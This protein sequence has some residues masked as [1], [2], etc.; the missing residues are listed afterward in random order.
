MKPLDK[1]LSLLNKDK[2]IPVIGAGVSFATAGLPGWRGAIENGLQYAEHRR[3]GEK[4]LMAQIKT[5]VQTGDLVKAANLLKQVLK[6]PNHPFV[7]WVEDLFGNPQIRSKALIDSIHDLCTPILLTTNYDDLLYGPYKIQEKKIFDWSLHG[8]IARSL[9]KN[10]EFILHLHGVYSKPDTVILSLADYDQLAGQHGYKS[11]LQKLWTDYHFLFIGCSRDGIMD[12]DFSTVIDFMNQWF[13]DFPHEHFILM[14]EPEFSTG[15]HHEL[16][17]KCNVHA[18]SYGR[19]YDDLPRFINEINPNREKTRLRRE[20]YLNEINNGLERLNASGALINNQAAV[21]RFVQNSLPVKAYWIDSE[22]LKILEDI[23][24]KYNAALHDKRQQLAASQAIVR[25]LISINKLDENIELWNQN[26]ANPEKLRKSGMIDTALMAFNCLRAFPKEMLDEIRLRAWGAIHGQYFDGNFDHFISEIKL[27]RTETNEHL[28][29]I[30]ADRYFFENM[31]RIIQS[32]QGV[33][34]LEPAKVFPE[35]NEAVVTKETN[36]GLLFLAQNNISLRHDEFPYPVQASL[37]GETSLSF[38]S[39]AFTGFESEKFVIGHTSQYVFC[40]NPN[41]DILLRKFYI[42]EVGSEISHV[43]NSRTGTDLYTYIFCSDKLVA[44]KNLERYFETPIQ[45]N[46]HNVVLLDNERGFLSST[47][48]AA[49]I[50]GN[51]ISRITING[52][53]SPL[54]TIQELWGIVYDIPAVYDVLHKITNGKVPAL[55]DGYIQGTRISESSWFGE[56][57]IIL[58]ATISLQFVKSSFLIVFQFKDEKLK[59]LSR[60]FFPHRFCY[61]HTLIQR[62]NEM[63]LVAGY[64]ATGNFPLI[65]YFKGINQVFDTTINGQPAIIQPL[66]KGNA[67]ILSMQAI[68]ADRVIAIQENERLYDIKL[69]DMTERSM[70]VKNLIRVTAVTS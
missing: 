10:E 26:W 50:T 37:P 17:E 25:G 9:Q 45:A 28:E 40:W 21:D 36:F 5:L 13:P 16:L 11:I 48:V 38:K 4:D 31:K 15:V 69:Q 51:F 22:E 57:V 49:N 42:A 27:F 60:V 23:L 62:S 56:Q 55:V 8:Q 30:F 19:G 29:Q 63:N 54:L 53:V 70:D 1:L 66:T 3:F 61:T 34:A 20:A 35:L 65:Q 44:F 24:Y 14:R 6:A 2:V 64:L 52:I 39:A 68:S 41:K 46:V 7:D 43:I 47:S 67:D 32:L 59:V 58:T 33:L 12:P 18:I